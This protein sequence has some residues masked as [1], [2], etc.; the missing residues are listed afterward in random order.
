MNRYLPTKEE[1]QPI[2]NK[3]STFYACGF[4]VDFDKLSFKKQLEVANDLI[5]QTMIS[6]EKPELSNEI[7]SLIG[8]C[9]TAALATIDYLKYLNVGFNHRL[10]LCRGRPY[11]PIDIVS[12]H[13]AVLVDDE[14][15]NTYFVDSTPYVG[16]MFG[17]VVNCSERRVYRDFFVL[18]GEKFD[19]FTQMREIIHKGSINA[20]K[21]GDFYKYKKC[22][23]KSMKYPFFN[24]HISQCLYYLSQT[25][26]DEKFKQFMLKK[27]IELDPYE[28]L[29][30]R[31]IKES[32]KRKYMICSQIE[33]WQTK[34]RLL[35]EQSSQDF[36]QEFDYARYIFQEKKLQ[37][38]SMETRVKINNYNANRISNL[39]PRMFL[40][41]GLNVVMLKPSAFKANVVEQIKKEIIND[42]N[43]ILFRYYA[44]LGKAK[45]ITGI[46]PMYYSHPV[47]LAFERAM[48]GPSEIM[49]VN[50]FAKDLY[51]RKKHLRSILAQE[52]HNKTIKWYDGKDI[53]WEPDMLNLVHTTDDP[54][55]ACLHFNISQPEQQLMTRFMY[56]NPIFGQIENRLYEKFGNTQLNQQERMIEIDKILDEIHPRVNCNEKMISR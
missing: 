9:H 30:G 52:C 19:L 1:L 36:N 21:M 56:P 23:S 18:D 16:Y 44:N 10:V 14:G 47:G 7:D 15:G 41:N 42:E 4:N 51:N 28:S 31:G 3:Y 37:D 29:A 25:I 53:V 12:R 49:L 32:F 34:L 39:T 54:C 55:E 11:D 48:Y 43:E 5:R 26:C 27:S 20:L 33:D 24:G 6:D 17:K 35:Q 46:H 50:H 45:N 13:T 40:E 22:L 8:N 38:D 2:T